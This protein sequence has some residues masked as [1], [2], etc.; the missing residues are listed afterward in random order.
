VLIAWSRLLSGRLRDPLVGRDLMAGCLF[1]GV[2]S[3]LALIA[4]AYKVNWKLIEPDSFLGGQVVLAEVL[5][6]HQTAL[7]RGIFFLAVF[8]A[9]RVLFRRTWIAV[10]GFTLYSIY[11]FG[12]ET[13]S[14]VET[15]FLAAYGLTFALFIMRFG[16]VAA[17]AAVFTKELLL[18]VPLTAEFSQWYA[19]AG[20]FALAAVLVVAGYGFYTSTL[21]GRN[22][23][24]DEL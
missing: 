6:C 10:I 4:I 21:A 14:M 2:W 5:K 3:G 16:L 23:I 8:L 18:T 15:V 24:A 9:M 19:Q 12:S 1:G 11:T 22:L 7:M 20:M 13:P 17:I